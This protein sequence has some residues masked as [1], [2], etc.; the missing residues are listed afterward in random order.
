MK[1]IAVEP[2]EPKTASCEDV[3]EPDA[4]EGSVLV[5]AIALFALTT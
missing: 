1:A 3:Q 2:E 4:H 5:Q